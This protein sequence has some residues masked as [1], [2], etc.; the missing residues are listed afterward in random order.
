MATT[1]EILAEALAALDRHL[2]Q[3]YP[4]SRF[5]GISFQEQAQFLTDWLAEHEA[6]YSFMTAETQSDRATFYDLEG[7]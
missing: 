7:N 6:A 5:R 1:V 3:L 4:D 2:D